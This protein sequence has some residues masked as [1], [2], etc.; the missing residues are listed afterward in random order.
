MKKK[1]NQTVFKT[2]FISFLVVVALEILLLLGSVFGTRIPQRLKRNAEQILTEQVENRAAYLRTMLLEAQNLTSLFDAVVERTEQKLK[3]GELSCEQ[4]NDPEKTADLLRDLSGILIRELRARP[5]TGIFVILNTQDLDQVS[6]PYSMPGIYLRDLDPDAPDSQRNEDIFLEFASSKVVQSLK[7]YT[8]SCW[9]PSYDYTPQSGAFVYQPYQTAYTASAPLSCDVYGYWSAEPFCL[10]GDSKE[11]ITYSLPLML[12]DGTVFGVAGV[13]LQTSYLKEKLPY[14]ELQYQEKGS[15]LLS[16]TD[17]AEGAE[18]YVLTP[19]ISASQNMDLE[20]NTEKIFVEIEGERNQTRIGKNDYSV[21]SIP[22]MLYRRNAPFSSEQW[23]LSGAVRQSQLYGIADLVQNL[24]LLIAFVM[25]L[26]GIASSF[27][28]T[29]KITRPIRRL[30]G[31]IAEFESRGDKEIPI[32]SDT[33]IREFDN[34]ADAF[35]KLSRSVLDASTR[36]L[37]IMDMAS[38][39]LGGYEVRREDETIYVTDNFFSMLGMKVSAEEVLSPDHFRCIMEEFYASAKLVPTKDAECMVFEIAHPGELPHFILLRTTE[40]NGVKIGLLEDITESEQE[41]RRL[42]YDRDY[43]VL[44]GLYNRRAF[45]FFMEKLLTEPQRLMHGALLA[46]DLDNLK[47]VNDT[48]GHD[49][50]DQYICLAGRYISENLPSASVCS[51]FS[52]DEFFAFVYGYEH[53]AVLEE[54]LRQF[55]H[56]AANYKLEAPNGEAVSLCISCGAAKYPEDSAVFSELRIYADFALYQVKRT[57]KGTLRL[58]DRE[59]YRQDMQES[60]MNRDFLQLL[61]DYSLEYHFQPIY[62]AEDG[63]TVAYEALMRVEKEMLKLPLDVIR[64][65]KKHNKL[66]ELEKMTL[67]KSTKTFLALQEQSLLEGETRLFINSLPSVALTEEDLKLC[68]PRLEQL[69]GRIVLEMNENET[70]EDEILE[71]KK[72]QFGGIAVFALDDYGSGYSNSVNL[73]R[74][75][76]EYIKLD[77]SIIHAIDSDKDKQQIVKNITEY[78]HIRGK[79]VIA[80]GIETAAELQCVLDLGVDFLQGYFLCRPAAVPGTLSREAKEI[81]QSHYQKQTSE[82]KQK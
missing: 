60:M 34:F 21:H 16:C 66:Y 38:I 69:R 56:L 29:T 78:A 58:F 31:E 77:Y 49:W 76:P 72:R 10:P 13:E 61:E 79:Y 46:F 51:H 48:Y 52:G 42:E 65:A 57:E 22:L 14:Q 40:E 19:V 35:T 1:Q 43:D 82:I 23:I 44:T 47:R 63:K 50:G 45:L 5:V 75:S 68:F 20:E 32:L 55:E 3:T 18:E 15:Y 36:F 25:L 64:L 6:A 33:G 27:I 39:E 67:W 73:L 81:L 24:F 8:D 59:K 71:Q 28:L 62:R 70:L 9:R 26:L 2:I 37:K 12:S 41:R 17:A 4:L 53:E 54:F 7:I 74:L 80:E 30:M 11:I